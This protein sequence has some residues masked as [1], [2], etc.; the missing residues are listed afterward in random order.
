MFSFFKSKKTTPDL[1]FIGVD[2]HSHILPQLDDGSQSMDDSIH[3]LEELQEMGYEK[4]ICTPHTLAEVHPNSPKTILPRLAEVKAEL[5][6]RNIDIPIHAASEYMVDV[7]M[8]AKL[9]A[10]E[11]MLTMGGGK[12]MLIEMSYL[13]ES[14][15]IENVVFEL[16]TKG[17]QP[18]LAHPERYNFY[19]HNFAKY[20][21][22]KEMGCLMQSNLLSFLGYYG[23][24]VQITAE[25][26]AKEKLV[27]LLGT[28]LHHERHLNAL[29]EL[30]SQKSFYKMVEGLNI[31]NREL[32][33]DKDF[34]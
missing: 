19:H 30:A 9:N 4:F 31:R 11:Q 1:S 10:G 3:F 20:H 16:Q 14:A 13:A 17:I 23:K 32:L 34:E 21:R 27:D 33:W 25:K 12:Y 26:L 18:I 15:N 24:H 2:M 29:K 8:E 6:K 7:S 22:M 28:D 5:K